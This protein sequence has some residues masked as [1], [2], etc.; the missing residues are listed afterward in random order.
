MMAPSVD[1]LARE[2]A[3]AWHRIE[4]GPSR[5]GLRDAMRQRVGLRRDNDGLRLVKGRCRKRGCP[6]R[7]GVTR[8]TADYRD[9]RRVDY[10]A[11][12]ECARCGRTWRRVKV[13]EWTSYQSVRLTL[14]LPH[15]QRR[16][17]ARGRWHSEGE[18]GI[19]LR[20]ARYSDMTAA[21][22]DWRRRSGLRLAR[23][24]R[25]KVRKQ[26]REAQG[27]RDVQA[28]IARLDARDAERVAER[29]GGDSLTKLGID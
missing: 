28:L 15:A 13:P 7:W 4:S 17:Y 1:A 26:E 8:V 25:A 21:V 5:Q 14:I 19:T 11:M 6:S 22:E 2:I 12:V 27:L 16:W 10:L 18:D 23:L 9:A 3:V 29:E 24:D 20:E